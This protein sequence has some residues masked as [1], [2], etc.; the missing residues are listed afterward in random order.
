M[1]TSGRGLAVAGSSSARV[2]GVE[3]VLDVL[4]RVP[5]VDGEGDVVVAEEPYVEGGVVVADEVPVDGGVVVVEP[6][7]EGGVVVVV[8]VLVVVDVSGFCPSTGRSVLTGRPVVDPALEGMAAR[9]SPASAGSPRTGRSVLTGRCGLP[10][11]SEEVVPMAL[12]VPGW[13]P[14]PIVGDSAP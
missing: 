14:V 11:R 1:A 8:V 6:Y 7:V 4:V 12:P 13:V 5:L 3:A 9:S 2:L 10:L